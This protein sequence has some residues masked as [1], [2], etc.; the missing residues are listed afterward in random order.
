MLPDPLGSPFLSAVNVQFRNLS[1]EVMTTAS[2]QE[3]STLLQARVAF[4][5]SYQKADCVPTIKENDRIFAI[6]NLKC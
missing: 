3:N 5:V 1:Y 4:L 6:L 2:T